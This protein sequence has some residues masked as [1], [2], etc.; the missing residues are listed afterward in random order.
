MIDQ[1]PF[2][3]RRIPSSALP[4]TKPPTRFARMLALA[5]HVED[6]IDRGVLTSYAEAAA[7]RGVSRARIAQVCGCLT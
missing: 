3:E 1:L 5:Y 4:K 7:R 6:L 2:A